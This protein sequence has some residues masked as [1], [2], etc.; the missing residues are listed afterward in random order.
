MF[1]AESLEHIVS[2]DL[3]RQSLYI[4]ILFFNIHRERLY[5]CR[6]ATDP[7]LMLYCWGLQKKYPQAN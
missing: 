7:L 6:R 4:Y 1:G 5:V 3:T 2:R